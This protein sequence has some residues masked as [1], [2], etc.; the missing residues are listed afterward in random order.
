MEL[1]RRVKR[2]S[3]GVATVI[4]FLMARVQWCRVQASGAM[5]FDYRLTGLG[6]AEARVSDGA[7]TATITASYLDDAL[8]DLLE[9]VGVLLEGAEEARCSWTEEPGESRW[10]FR[11]EGAAVQLRVLVF[12]GMYSHEPDGTGVVVFDTLQPLREVARAIAT[13]AQAV[14]DEHGEDGYLQRWY[15]HPFPSGHLE[16]IQVWLSA[17]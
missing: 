17:S 5:E 12:P 7:S 11:R 10:T 6:W 3:R 4:P 16:A 2:P 8:G 9:A 1:S 14:L 15:E 13:G